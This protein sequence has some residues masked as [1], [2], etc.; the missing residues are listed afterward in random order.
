M[1]TP[2]PYTYMHVHMHTHDY[3]GLVSFIS[4]LLLK[5][6]KSSGDIDLLLGHPSF[7]SDNKIK[8]RKRSA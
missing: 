7:V 1:W 4:A 5:G 2:V 3:P 6:A 8:V